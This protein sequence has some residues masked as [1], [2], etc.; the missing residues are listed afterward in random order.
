MFLINRSYSNPTQKEK[1]KGGGYSPLAIAEGYSK[2]DHEEICVAFDKQY[3]GLSFSS[4]DPGG[5]VMPRPRFTFQ[6]CSSG[7]V[8]N[9]LLAVDLKS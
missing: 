1:K 7:D 2:S 3:T 6:P 8:A 4:T 9:A 5:Q